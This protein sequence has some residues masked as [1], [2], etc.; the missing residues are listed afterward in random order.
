MKAVSSS[1]DLVAAAG[2]WKGSL[3]GGTQFGWIEF[4]ETVR[5]VVVPRE[6]A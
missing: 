1:A 6:L 5:S 3:Q 4:A 2:C